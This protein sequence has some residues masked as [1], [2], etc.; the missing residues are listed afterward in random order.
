MEILTKMTKLSEFID[1]LILVIIAVGHKKVN[2]TWQKS[3]PFSG[4]EPATSRFIDLAYLDCFKWSRKKDH[5]F[6][7]SWKQLFRSRIVRGTIWKRLF[8]FI[9]TKISQDGHILEI[10]TSYLRYFWNSWKVLYYKLVQRPRIPLDPHSH[11]DYCQW[12]SRSEKPV[13]KFGAL[14]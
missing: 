12:L 11:Q 9:H 10:G 2:Y 5:P 13:F 6:Y 7:F 4:S 3:L 1:V 14:Q 8:W